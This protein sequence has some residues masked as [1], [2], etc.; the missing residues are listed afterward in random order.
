MYLTASSQEIMLNG[1]QDTGAP[2]AFNINVLILL[3]SKVIVTRSIYYNRFC[4]KEQLNNHM[5]Y[6]T[7]IHS[8][9][10]N[11][12]KM[13]KEAQDPVDTVTVD[14]P[15]LTRLLELA[16]EDIKTDAELHFVLTR[17][18]ELKN[19]GVLTMQDYEQITGPKPTELE[20]IKK[21]AGI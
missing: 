3:L 6:S 20:S 7:L 19:K 11:P 9:I 18:L 16:R 15:L 12:P 13:V 17:I 2:S 21:L 14:V 8:G 1:S 10:V 4:P 5:T